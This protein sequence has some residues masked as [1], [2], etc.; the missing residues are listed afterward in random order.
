MILV[1]E[2]YVWALDLST[3]KTDRQVSRFHKQGSKC[4]PTEHYYG[5]PFNPTGH[6]ADTKAEALDELTR[7][8]ETNPN[9]YLV[10]VVMTRCTAEEEQT[11]DSLN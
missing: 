8:R 4:R 5:G 9:T 1:T 3:G 7:L 11:E 6:T 10:K 2:L